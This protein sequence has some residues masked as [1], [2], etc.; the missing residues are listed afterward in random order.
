MDYNEPVQLTDVDRVDILTVS[1]L[2]E[3]ETSLG[4]I[5]KDRGLHLISI[6]SVMDEHV[7]QIMELWSELPMPAM[8]ARCHMPTYGLGFYRQ[9]TFLAEWTICWR[10]NN[11]FSTDTDLSGNKTFDG[12]APSSRQLLS[13]LNKLTNQWVED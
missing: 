10:C 5:S 1:R 11:M 8:P 13:L 7:Q 6:M 4:I 9:D 12:D 2:Y 3:G